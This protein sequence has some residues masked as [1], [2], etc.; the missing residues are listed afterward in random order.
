MDLNNF[1]EQVYKEL[2][3]ERVNYTRQLAD[4]VD[5]QIRIIAEIEQKLR[6]EY[7]GYLK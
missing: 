5:C 2:Q 1:D 4:A 6:N 7:R 3:N